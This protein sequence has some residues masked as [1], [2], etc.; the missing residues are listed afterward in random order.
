MQ[1]QH[2]ARTV[3]ELDNTS[4][5]R[6]APHHRLHLSPPFMSYVCCHEMPD[7][8]HLNFKSKMNPIPTKARRFHALQLPIVTKASQQQKSTRQ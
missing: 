3:A 7:H 8:L 4:L 1:L 6:Q 5:K 2:F